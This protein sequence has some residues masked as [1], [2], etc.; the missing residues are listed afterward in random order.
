MQVD[1]SELE[2]QAQERRARETATSAAKAAEEAR[3][4]AID[5]EVQRRHI[6]AANIRRKNAEMLAKRHKEQADDKQQQDGVLREV[7]S[8]K[9]D[10]A[11]YFSQF[12]TSHR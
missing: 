4:L 1:I 6:E 11:A 2:R 8:N 5:A 9:V 3:Q 10:T 7:Y 12:G